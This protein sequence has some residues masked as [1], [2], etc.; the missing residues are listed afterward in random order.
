MAVEPPSGTTSFLFTDVE[1]STE[2]ARRAGAGYPDLVKIH[3]EIIRAVVERESGIVVKTTGDGV[4]AAFAA[5]SAALDAA[6]LIQSNIQGH[7]WP[8]GVEI[9]VR[10]GVH[11]GE[12]TMYE[13]DYVGLE[14][15]RAA[16]VMSA[17]H[18]GQI[19][20]SEVARSLAGDGY[21]FRDL[22]R[23]LLKGLDEEETIFQL[24]V[25]GLPAE[26]PPLTTASVIPNNLP[27]RATSIVGRQ[28]DR[29]HV[30]D[31]IDANRLVTLLGQGGVGKTAL[32]LSV[33]AGSIGSFPG[34]VTFVD[35]SSVNDSAY[36]I[37]AIAAELDAEPKTLEAVSARLQRARNLLVLDNFEQVVAAAP[38]V[39]RLMES[40]ADTHLLVTS[41]VPVR[42]AGEQRYI[43]EALPID[44]GPEAPGA[45]MFLERAR[46]V[47]PDFEA[48]PQVV[49]EL[50]RFLDGLPLAIELVAARAN[51]LTA[52][53][54]LDRLRSGRMS[55]GARADSPERQRSLEAALEWSHD[56]LDL[57]TKDVFRRL[58]AFAGG[59]TLEAADAVAGNAGVDVMPAVAE[60]VDRSLVTRRFDSAGRF[61]MLD[62]IRRFA[63]ARLGESDVREQTVGRLVDYYQEMARGAY[64]GLQSDRG[65][66]WQTQLDEELDN[67]REVLAILRDRGRSDEGLG[68]IGDLW[69]FYVSR[70]Y[71]VEMK[72]WLD[73]FLGMP[74][75]SAT[76]PERVKGLMAQGAFRYWQE[77]GEDAVESYEIAVQHARVVG[78][79][80]LLADALFGLATS[81]A[82]AGRSDEGAQVL[83][84]SK[85]IY[86]RLGDQS[87]LADV[88]AGEGFVT[89]RVTGLAGKGPMFEEASRLYEAVGRRVQST[90]TI[91]AESAAAI[92]EARFGEAK[93]IAARGL[94]RAVDL[95]DLLLQAW[96]VDY[97]ARIEYELGDYERAGLFAGAVEVARA[98][99]GAGWG[100]ES[101]GLESGGAL[102]RA[103]LGEERAE[104]LIAAGRRLTLEE[105]VE[106]ALAD[107]EGD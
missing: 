93:G 42:L 5:V 3:D 70:G 28:V 23:H 36:V 87:G 46:S 7:D 13:G 100:P 2:L 15:H 85:A 91:Y 25:P 107:D 77:R 14:V 98:M 52:E 53:Q 8:L 66:W 78:D 10:V 54:M 51:L 92:A 30:A 102:L 29:E 105:A 82:I 64:T 11:T 50:V 48:D 104:R 16:R 68:V 96:G 61:R 80:R 49:T 34:G 58:G 71:A 18:G 19:L 76:S 26:F 83:A 79:D 47:S 90:Q 65:H 24:I 97:M 55:F 1:S 60:L 101:V 84:E 67:F 43:V 89:A 35:F 33:A 31:L 95:S 40:A 63:K 39:G 56:L 88:V 86:G 37:S 106:L 94:R 20:V 99:L 57:R 45:A 27:A 44:G 38:D 12:A 74:I 103:D 22:G 81:L 69:R 17:G 72:T 59:F 62:G 41:Q 32:A 73:S 75:P 21:E 9:K 4:F 6:S